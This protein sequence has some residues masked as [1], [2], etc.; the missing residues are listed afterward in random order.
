M[1]ASLYGVGGPQSMAVNHGGNNITKSPQV[2]KKF[3]RD[4][5][6]AS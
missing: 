5:Y 2:N 4:Y 3:R 1:R 6:I